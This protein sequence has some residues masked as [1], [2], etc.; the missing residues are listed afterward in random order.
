MSGFAQKCFLD[1]TRLDLI[2]LSQRV[3]ETMRRLLATQF[4]VA[5]LGWQPTKQLR[6][7][8]LL[9]AGLAI[10]LEKLLPKLP[11]VN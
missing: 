6:A 8:A 5:A 11:K 7:M 1:D 4:P 9:R 10:T 2:V 3:F